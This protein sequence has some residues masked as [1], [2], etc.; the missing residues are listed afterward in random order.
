MY[1]LVGHDRPAHIHVYRVS[2]QKHYLIQCMFV[3]QDAIDVC[4]AFV[5]L[6]SFYWSYEQIFSSWANRYQC[7]EKQLNI[8]NWMIVIMKQY[9]PSSLVY[10]I[11]SEIYDVIQSILLN[12]MKCTFYSWSSTPVLLKLFFFQPEAHCGS[13]K[14]LSSE[15]LFVKNLF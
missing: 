14:F 5:L 6:H 15:Q 12:C 2:Q 9:A 13:Y 8:I 1:T 10:I 7:F 4:W 3:P 11:F